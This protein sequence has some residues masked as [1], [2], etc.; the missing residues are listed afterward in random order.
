MGTGDLRKSQQDR[1]AQNGKFDLA[2]R[3]SCKLEKKTFFS[4]KKVALFVNRPYSNEINCK[5]KRFFKTQK[6]GAELWLNFPTAIV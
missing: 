6:K 1:H 5:D 2:T 4:Q 3:K